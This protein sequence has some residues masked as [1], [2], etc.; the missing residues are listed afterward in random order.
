MHA[1]S[2]DKRMPNCLSFL[3]SAGARLNGTWRQGL[4]LPPMR[5]NRVCDATKS[6]S[7]MGHSED[8]LLSPSVFKYDKQGGQ[9]KHWKAVN[10]VDVADPA[11]FVKLSR[12]ADD[13]DGEPK[14]QQPTQARQKTTRASGRA[15]DRRTSPEIERNATSR[16]LPSGSVAFEGDPVA[17]GL[18]RNVPRYK[19]GPP[20]EAFI[21]PRGY[22]ERSSQIAEDLGFDD[23]GLGSGDI[24]SVL[25]DLEEEVGLEDDEWL[26]DFLGELGLTAQF[27]SG[28]NLW[29]NSSDRE[30]MLAVVS[31]FQWLGFTSE[32]VGH[33]VGTVPRVLRQDPD[34]QLMPLAEFLM[35]QMELDLEDLA[36]YPKV[37]TVNLYDRLMPRFYFL[38]NRHQYM[39][40][41]MICS[42]SDAKFV[43]L[44]NATANEY[45]AFLGEYYS[46][47]VDWRTS[48][49]FVS[50]GASST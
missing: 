39:R 3:L 49:P 21:D 23:L 10:Q 11:A 15:S 34:T 27:L 30:R 1:Q 22:D 20:P 38:R 48:S 7:P 4:S 9:D 28:R 40:L 14:S 8:S 33:I 50:S 2:T 31:F 6:H 16:P 12:H 29:N 37:F 36:G 44:T 42:C 43:E 25:R 45:R 26:E 24:P 35:M 47:A 19:S 46:L 5:P 13:K 32:Q 41:N 17:A 18:V